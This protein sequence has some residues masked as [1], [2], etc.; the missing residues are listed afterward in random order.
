MFL[1]GD[2]DSTI[3]V[4]PPS[5]SPEVSAA[6]SYPGI[7]SLPPEILSHIFVVGSRKLE[8][9]YRTG[10]EYVNL[11]DQNDMDDDEFATRCSHVC[12][13][14]RAVAINTHQLWSF[15]DFRGLASEE[16]CKTWIERSQDVPLTIEVAHEMDGLFNPEE[17]GAVTF[18]EIQRAYMTR[19]LI[20]PH[21]RR[22]KSFELVTDSYE[23]VWLWERSLLQVGCAPI[24]EHIG[25]FCHGDIPAVTVTHLRPPSPLVIFPQGTPKIRS[26]NLW[27][28]H[29]DWDL[30]TFFTGL[31]NL[32][33]AWH[34]EHV[35]LTIEQFVQA[36]RRSPKL[37]TLILEGSAPIPGDWPQERILLPKLTMLS[38]VGIDL[39]NAVSVI[40]HL[41]FPALVS[42]YSICVICS[43]QLYRLNR[44]TYSWT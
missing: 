42:I 28:V 20:L 2:S 11:N 14:W 7:A 38:L 32:Q 21:A 30:V 35:R 36:L 37:E 4:T 41:D 40:D 15:L 10:C 44:S 33:L 31:E 16:R 9:G 8:V 23:L 5:S 24:L 13:Y 22:W 12:Q 1:Q 27:G 34:S 6:T 3:L 25:L 29:F 26:V 39:I 18:M 17:R 43:C 19:D